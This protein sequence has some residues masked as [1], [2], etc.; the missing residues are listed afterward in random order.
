MDGPRDARARE[1]GQ[2]LV[3][4]AGGAIALLLLVGLVL[5]GGIAYF[6]RRDAQNVADV[7]AM[8]GTAEI[9]DGY[10]EATT[11]GVNIRT[12]ADVYD[13]IE[14]SV[15]ENGCSATGAVPCQWSARFV[16]ENAADKGAVNDASST[17][18]SGALGV[19]VVVERQPGTFLARLASI[20][21]WNVVSEA[22]AVAIKPG[23]APPAGLLPIALKNSPDPN[24]YQPGQ[25]YDL[26]DGKDAPGGFG[27]LSWDGSNDPNALADSIC[28]PDNPAFSLEPATPFPGGPGKM[29]DTGVRA[30]LEEYISGDKAGQVVLIPIYDHVSGTG[31]NVSY[32]I[33]G[34]AAFKIVS[35]SQPSVDNISGYFVNVYPFASAP[36]GNWQ[37]PSASDTTYWLGLIR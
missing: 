2:V 19:Q 1:R 23:S 20:D 6:N 4:V 27:W 12:Q 33:V 10:T 14:L 31:N 17:L 29:N 3:I 7:A 37:A 24:L 35:Y 28:D 18:P 22:T 16:G 32:N 8:A 34:L 36:A 30:C 15:A 21:E 13:R 11:A 26:T 5:D 25:V 9:A